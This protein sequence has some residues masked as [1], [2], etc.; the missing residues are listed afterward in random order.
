MRLRPK[1]VRPSNSAPQCTAARSEKNWLA[2]STNELRLCV[3]DVAPTARGNSKAGSCAL[4]VEAIDARARVS[5][6]PKVGTLP[7]LR[8]PGR[9]R[10]ILRPPAARLRSSAS[11]VLVV[12]RLYAFFVELDVELVAFELLHVVPVF[13]VEFVL[14]HLER[15]TCQRGRARQSQC[16]SPPPI[17]IS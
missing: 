4:E 13:V 3:I 16:P 17:A 15:R 5:D 7:S 6:S 1:K 8:P 2:A 11:K 12:F 14:G 9:G 10:P